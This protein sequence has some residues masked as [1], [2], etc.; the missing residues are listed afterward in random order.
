LEYIQNS[1]DNRTEKNRDALIIKN[2]RNL[3][4]TPAIMIISHDIK[5]SVGFA[6]RILIMENG[7]FV[8]SEHEKK[9]AALMD[10]STA[11][12]G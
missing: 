4:P 10:I 2:I 8:D 6:D 7:T 11:G 12:E 1:A 3:T 5:L 9:L